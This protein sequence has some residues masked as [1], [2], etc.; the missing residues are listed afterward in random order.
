[1]V[2]KKCFVVFAFLFFLISVNVA[3]ADFS[4]PET[5]VSTLYRYD[6]N[7]TDN[8]TAIA[9]VSLSSDYL[10]SEGKPLCKLAAFSETRRNIDRNDTSRQELGFELGKDVVEWF[11]I[12]ASLKYVWLHENFEYE[13]IFQRSQG[14]EIEPYFVLSNQL[15]AYKDFKVD[16]FIED[17]A[18]YDLRSG[19]IK[20][21]EAAFGLVFPFSEHAATTVSWRHIDR[22]HYYDSDLFDFGFIFNF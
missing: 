9:V 4:K 17:A 16:W 19:Y 10:D 14:M 3:F 6:P 1:M 13:A 15:F 18:T 5:E 22:I 21:N 20:R 2:V 11:Y 8:N 12:G 7:N